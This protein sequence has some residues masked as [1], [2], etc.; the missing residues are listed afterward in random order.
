M[1]KQGGLWTHVLAPPTR[2]GL[3]HLRQLPANKSQAPWA[4]TDRSVG[5]YC[6]CVA[7]GLP[8]PPRSRASSRSRGIRAGRRPRRAADT[9]PPLTEAQLAHVGVVGPEHHSGN[10]QHRHPGECPLAPAQPPR[11]RHRHGRAGPGRLGHPLSGAGRWGV[12]GAVGLGARLR[13]LAAQRH[14]AAAAL[15]LLPV[16]ETLLRMRG[17]LLPVPGQPVQAAAALGRDP[18]RG[19]RGDQSRP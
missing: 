7:A 10:E 15:Q 12:G 4:W 5:P 16:G 19:R 8:P 14:L 9:R 17:G 11:Q 6:A 2:A 1:R 3:N 18:H 13:S